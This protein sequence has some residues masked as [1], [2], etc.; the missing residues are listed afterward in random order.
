M[1]VYSS[2]LYNRES[3]HH[4][5]ANQNTLSKSSIFLFIAQKLEKE[6]NATYFLIPF[7]YHIYIY[8]EAGFLC[9]TV[10]VVLDLALWTRLVLNS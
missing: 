1:R 10:L 2:C 6:S 9:I 8:F 3:N 4:L 7:S 5:H